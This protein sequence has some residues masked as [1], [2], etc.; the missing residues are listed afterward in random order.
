MY[1]HTTY[2]YISTYMHIQILIMHHILNMLIYI[3]IYIHIYIIYRYIHIYLSDIRCT[4]PCAP[5]VPGR[6]VQ[7]DV[8][9]G[10]WEGRPGAV[11]KRGAH[12]DGYDSNVSSMYI[13]YNNLCI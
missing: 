2:R 10:C 13:I 1:V 9:R 7:P 3:Y 4:F 6:P 5:S 11:P 12:Y 8:P